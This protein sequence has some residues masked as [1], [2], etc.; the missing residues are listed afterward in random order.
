VLLL[1]S[2]PH[3][4]LAPQPAVA[5]VVVVDDDP[6][7]V[8][9]LEGL[10]AAEGYR[11]EGFTDPTVALDR[12]RRGAPP[13]LVIADCI[14]P[15]LTGAELASAL[16]EAGVPVPVLLMTALSDPSF[17]VH[18]GDAVVLNKPFLIDDLLLEMEALL[19]PRSGA[20]RTRRSG[21][22]APSR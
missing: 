21:V 4:Q 2:H 9:T 3:S 14:M 10:L 6:S 5:S 20:R 19:L 11:V 16:A 17:C 1:M 18:P 7:L 22:Y 8:E 12:L 13:D 15:G